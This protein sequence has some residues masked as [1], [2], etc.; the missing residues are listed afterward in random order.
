MPMANDPVSD[1]LA[2]FRPERERVETM[3]WERAYDAL[4]ELNQLYKQMD[5]I[6]HRYARQLGLSDTA[7]WILYSMGEETA[8]LTQRELCDIW[9]YP[10]QTVNS[11]LKGLERQGLIALVPRRGSR[12]DKEMV[13]TGPGR[14]CV[15]RWIDP[16]MEAERR[17]LEELGAAEREQLFSITRRYIRAL[18][19]GAQAL[20]AAAQSEK[21]NGENL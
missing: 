21:E 10:P 8:P 15:R 7:F 3:E 13:L 5:G 19:A 11:A 9:H 20:P 6:Y 17:A 14:A 16:L 1:Y 12:K 18:E 2:R 4:E